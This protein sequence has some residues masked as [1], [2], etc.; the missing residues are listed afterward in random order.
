MINL[1]GTVVPVLDLLC[2]GGPGNRRLYLRDV[3][4]L[5]RAEGKYWGGPKKRIDTI[6]ELPGYSPWR[7]TKVAITLFN[8]NKDFWRGLEAIAGQGRTYPNF[9]R[10][11][12]KSSETVFKYVF[13]HKDDVNRERF[14]A[15]LTLDVLA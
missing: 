1:Y 12:G 7:D 6:A 14:L 4:Y 5:F 11:L 3:H 10:D 8:R 13:A 9:Q 15:I 2:T